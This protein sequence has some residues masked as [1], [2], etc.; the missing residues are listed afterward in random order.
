MFENLLGILSAYHQYTVPI[1]TAQDITLF[2]CEKFMV[3]FTESST[4]PP[5]SCERQC[6]WSPLTFDEIPSSSFPP[7]CLTPHIITL[8]SKFFSEW[9]EGDPLSLGWV[10]CSASPKMT[11]LLI[12][13]V[14]PNRSRSRDWHT[15]LLHKKVLLEVD[16]RVRI[17]NFLS[18]QRDG[19]YII[20]PHTGW[21]F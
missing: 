3:S 16:F 20:E 5:K 14:I 15:E 18:K 17:Y 6:E 7:M 21:M 12:P 8:I 9:L 2:H 13:I 4:I 19:A 11:N 10:S 1:S